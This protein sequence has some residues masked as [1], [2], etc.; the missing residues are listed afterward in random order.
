MKKLIFILF[1]MIALGLGTLGVVLPVL[2]TTPFLLLA[3]YCF[4]N[5]SEKINKWFIGTPLYKKYLQNFEKNKGMP[6]KQKLITQIF[7]G[8]MMAFTFILIDKIFIRIFLVT[9]FLVFNYVFIFK[10]KTL[11]SHR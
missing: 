6:G 1:G 9:S 3:V 11:D 7:V 8:L 4:A 5:G 10:I 2:P